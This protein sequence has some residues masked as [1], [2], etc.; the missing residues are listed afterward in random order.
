M[1]AG[2]ARIRDG[3]VIAPT[4]RLENWMERAARD[5]A[6]HAIGTLYVSRCRLSKYSRQAR[7][8]HACWRWAGAIRRGP[9]GLQWHDS[10]RRASLDHRGLVRQFMVRGPGASA[11]R[12]TLFWPAAFTSS[13][14]VASGWR[15]PAVRAG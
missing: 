14:D 13:R 15:A 6:A 8:T 5:G 3:T 12:A 1:A 10:Y 2:F 9:R 7:S 4:P 11:T